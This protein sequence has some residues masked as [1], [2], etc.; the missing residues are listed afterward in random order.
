MQSELLDLPLNLTI[1]LLGSWLSPKDLALLDAAQCNRCSR[2]VYLDAL[3]SDGLIVDISSYENEMAPL[4]EWIEDRKVKIER[5]NLRNGG[6]Q[7]GPGHIASFL[8]SVGSNL[9][10]LSADNSEGYLTHTCCIA[11]ASCPRL[12]V[13][14]VSRCNDDNTEGT[15]CRLIAQ[16]AATLERLALEDSISYNV[17]PKYTEMKKL[18]Y[19]AILDSAMSKRNLSAFL[20]SC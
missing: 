12:K 6:W 7:I 3:R 17:L 15:I 16:R 11:I 14:H 9:L 1:E 13:L 20:C 2:E 5:V 10:D 18:Q 19:L 4:M 8:G